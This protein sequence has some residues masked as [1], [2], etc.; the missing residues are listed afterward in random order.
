MSEANIGE[1]SGEVASIGNPPDSATE[2]DDEIE[3]TF[4]DFAGGVH[5][6]EGTRSEGLTFAAAPR[7]ANLLTER[8]L[9]GVVYKSELHMC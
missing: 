4:V 2:A 8:V 3:E 5:G 7:R 6:G 1:V 9:E